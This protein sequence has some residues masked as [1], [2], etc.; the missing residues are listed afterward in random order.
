MVGG[1][2]SGCWDGGTAGVEGVGWIPAFGGVTVV[3]F[4]PIL[5]FP[6][7]GGRDFFRHTNEGY[8][9]GWRS[10]VPGRGSSKGWLLASA[11]SL[12]SFQAVISAAISARPSARASWRRF[13]SQSLMASLV[14]IM[15]SHTS[16][17]ITVLIMAFAPSRSSWL[18][19]TARMFR[20]SPSARA[21]QS[22]SDRSMRRGRIVALPGRRSA[23]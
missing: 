7:R 2:C 19:L 6:R 22:E 15:A 12:R 9:R 4:T 21:V 3:E 11:A 23:R 13:L 20:M 5:A 10:L 18:R 14:P 16:M 8:G 1:V 17:R